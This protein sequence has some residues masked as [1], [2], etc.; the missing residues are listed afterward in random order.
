MWH[1][2]LSYGRNYWDEFYANILQCDLHHDPTLGGDVEAAKYRDWYRAT[3]D[4]YER[5][6]GEKPPNDIWPSPYARFENAE[7][8]RRV[9]TADKFVIPK[10]S[11]GVLWVAQVISILAVLVCIWQG[12]TLWGWTFAFLAVGIYVYRGRVDNRGPRRRPGRDDNGRGG[13]GAGCG[14]FGGDSGGG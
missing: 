4:S 3:L 9:N 8:M 11:R 10:P 14:G 13:M 2:H 7:A 12:A 6:S 5:L 1:L